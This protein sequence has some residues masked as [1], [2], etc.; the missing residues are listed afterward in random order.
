VL[1][2]V[3]DLASL[4]TALKRAATVERV[5]LE[6]VLKYSLNFVAEPLAAALAAADA[7]DAASVRAVRKAVP[8]L[9]AQL[10]RTVRLFKGAITLAVLATFSPSKDT[11]RLLL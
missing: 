3:V 10:A 9:P 5:V 2:L 1:P 11:L 8:W 7:S 4:A 6:V